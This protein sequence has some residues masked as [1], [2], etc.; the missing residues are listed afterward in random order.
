M[1][2]ALGRGAPPDGRGETLVEILVAV[3]IL[4]LAATALLGALGTVTSASALHREQATAETAIRSY[5]EAVKAVGYRPGCS[6]P[7]RYT[8]SSVG[9]AVPDG[10][11]TTAPEVWYWHR[12][13]GP[14]DTDRFVPPVECP[15]QD[16]G[17][18]LVTLEVHSV[19]GQESETLRLAMRATQ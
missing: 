10:Y 14:A 18:Q 15:A 9:F 17:L 5:A 6:D 13:T 19:N 11:G 3:A 2:A 1:R 4:G 16:P 7:T 12:A 8:E